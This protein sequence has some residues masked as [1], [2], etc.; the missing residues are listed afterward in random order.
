MEVV[1]PPYNLQMNGLSGNRPISKHVGQTL[2]FDA[3]DTLWEN[4]IYFEQ[5]ITAF[6]SYLDHRVHTAE[7]V[8]EHLNHCERKTIAEYGYGL[9]SFHRSLMACFEQLSDVPI[10]PEKHERIVSFAHSI[11]DREIELLTGVEETLRELSTRQQL[12]LVTKGDLEEQTGKLE[13]SGLSAYFSR[14]EVLAEKNPAAYAELVERHALK[15]R[16]TWM[17]GNSPKSDINPSLAVG[18]NAVFIPHDFTWVLEHEVVDRP[19]SGQVLLELVK[20]SQL[21]NHF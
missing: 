13:R 18:M 1:F 15:P 20:F 21:L 8:R 17:I 5:A 10:T 2:L 4:N 7:E 19:G 3:D 9:K 12:F 6:I 11:A 14:V 16:K